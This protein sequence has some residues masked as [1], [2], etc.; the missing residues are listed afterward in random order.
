[1]HCLCSCLTRGQLLSSPDLGLR[2]AHHYE[3]AQRGPPCKASSPVR[4]RG[5]GW[6]DMAQGGPH[7][8]VVDP[9]PQHLCSGVGS[10]CHLSSADSYGPS[11]ILSLVFTF[12]PSSFS[13]LWSPVAQ[14]QP[15]SLHVKVMKEWGV[16]VLEQSLVLSTWGA[17][18][19][20]AEHGP[21]DMELVADGLGTAA[22]SQKIHSAL[23]T[24]D[25]MSSVCIYSSPCCWRWLDDLCPPGMCWVED[26]CLAFTSVF[27]SLGGFRRH[28]LWEDREASNLAI[29]SW[30][31]A[32]IQM[33]LFL[34]WRNTGLTNRVV[35]Y[36]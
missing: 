12:P 6:R 16:E 30:S 11:L 7:T 2:S 10:N 29:P 4:W 35:G 27:L 36:K 17:L 3:R 32:D 31:S 34:I 19:Q 20:R 28:V 18:Q 1:M 33:F 25:Q 5:L 14:H 23:S 24:A 21:I 9:H 22:L 13:P 26:I 15:I 8:A